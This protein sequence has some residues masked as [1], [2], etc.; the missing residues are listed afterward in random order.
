MR[1][2]GQ[3]QVFIPDKGGATVVL[4]DKKAV[5][6]GETL[7]WHIHCDNPAVKKVKIEFKAEAPI[8]SNMAED[9]HKLDKDLH[10]LDKKVH[11]LDK[12]PHD[13]DKKSTRTCS[14]AAHMPSLLELRA[15]KNKYRIV[16]L[17][18]DGVEI[19]ETE[20]DP[21]IIITDPG[22]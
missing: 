5:L 19:E 18:K 21:E 14:I 8:F 3:I 13:G 22:P 16:G 7:S 9:P 10:D 4:P 17:D 12:D 2:M 20:L 1:K 15:P 11:D 6:V